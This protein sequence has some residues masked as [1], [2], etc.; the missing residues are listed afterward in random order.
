M[1]PK[2]SRPPLLP[3][4]PIDIRF[5]AKPFFRW[6]V[7]KEEN[8]WVFQCSWPYSDQYNAKTP[9]PARLLR[10]KGKDYA[11]SK[12]V[13]LLLGIE[14]P[15]DLAVFIN[16]NGCPFDEV[17]ECPLE[18]EYHRRKV[19]FRWSDFQ[20]LQMNLRD[21]MRLPVAKLLR[22]PEFKWA[23]NLTSFKIEVVH[24]GGTYYGEQWTRASEPLCY[25]V[26]AVNRLLGEVEYGF[27]ERC[28]KP[29]QV[30]SRHKRKFCDTGC[31]HAAAQER[32]REGL[33]DIPPNR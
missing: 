17:V 33:R 8:D 1:S 10:V 30:T 3:T 23:F 4:L 11:G 22:R 31:A 20:R 19:P 24:E 13:E 6:E 9:I 2:R 14:K 25:R 27:C 18:E 7:T 16:V 29:F 15:R 12:Y 32:Y 26:I 21:A 28:R 5:R